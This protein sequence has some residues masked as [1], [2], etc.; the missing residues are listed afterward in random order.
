MTIS[1]NKF[2]YSLLVLHPDGRITGIRLNC[3]RWYSKVWF[4]ECKALFCT[5]SMKNKRKIYSV[6]QQV[7]AILMI[8]A[9]LWLTVSTPFVFA[10][11]QKLASQDKIEKNQLP[12]SGNEE[13]SSNPFSSTTEEKNPTSTS[14]SEEYLHDHH[15]ADHFFPI[16]TQYHTCG[17]SDTYIAYHGELHVPPPNAA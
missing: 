3:Q 2:D 14:F 7:S 10:S 8:L 6:F 9:L 5:L 16:A 12:L 4:K 13:E 1:L 17:N 15:V 11:Q